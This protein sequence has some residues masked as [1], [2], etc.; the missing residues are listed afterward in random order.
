MFQYAA[1][2]ALSEH[3][4]CELILDTTPLSIPADHTS[5]SYEL[6]AFNIKG[7]VDT[8]SD[9]QLHRMITLHESKV[10]D[11]WTKRIRRGT[12]L[13]GF[14]QSERYFKSIRTTLLDE[15]TLSRIPNDYAKGIADRIQAT[16]NAVSI[17][18]RRG[19]YVSN[20]KAAEF[21]GVCS[22]NYYENAIAHIQQRANITHAFVFSDDPEWVRTSASLPVSFTL[23]DSKESSAAQDVW[24]MSLCQHH[25]LANSSF[26]W[27]G[28]WLSRQEGINV[29]PLRW[30][31]NK[32]ARQD[33]I[34]PNNWIRM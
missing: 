4:G 7:S 5:R 31:Q 30:F 20:A 12:R 8:L 19:D 3:L 14:W 25:I 11:G 17:H 27:W 16:P 6:S 32:D 18:F 15:F 34:V 24:L 9:V 26:S 23:I 13:D 1:G 33:H 2:R 21:H 29:A 10:P 28:A 22:L